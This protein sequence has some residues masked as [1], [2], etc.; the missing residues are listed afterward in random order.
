MHRIRVAHPVALRS[1]CGVSQG[2]SLGRPAFPACDAGGGTT[3]EDWDKRALTF[4]AH[5]TR[6]GRGWPT[7]TCRDSGQSPWIAVAAGSRR[8]EMGPRNL[9]GTDL[10]E[11]RTT[12]GCLAAWRPI[13]SVHRRG[14]WRILA[15]NLLFDFLTAAESGTQAHRLARFGVQSA[16]MDEIFGDRPQLQFVFHHAPEPNQA[17]GIVHS[18]GIAAA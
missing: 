9:S 2:R 15:A 10:P 5:S 4:A 13:T 7:R 14:I 17:F 12:G 16:E 11:G 6:R 18:K 8:V 1:G 3:S